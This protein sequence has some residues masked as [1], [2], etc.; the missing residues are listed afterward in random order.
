MGL[1]RINVFKTAFQQTISACNAKGQQA[2]MTHI[3]LYNMRL[4]EDE[5]KAF[6]PAL[7]SGLYLFE[8]LVMLFKPVKH[9]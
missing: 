9:S 7:E 4:S 8:L 2:V 5:L 6:Q 1:V 3:F